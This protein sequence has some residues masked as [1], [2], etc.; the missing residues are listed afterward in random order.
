MEQE[1]SEDQIFSWKL[2][3]IILDQDDCIWTWETFFCNAIKSGYSSFWQQQLKK[4]KPKTK[5]TSH[6]QLKWRRGKCTAFV[7]LFTD[8]CFFE[9]STLRDLTIQSSR[10]FLNSKLKEKNSNCTFALESFRDFCKQPKIIL[11]LI[12]L[13]ILFWLFSTA[14]LKCFFNACAFCS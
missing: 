9:G 8:G 6:V 7:L 1:K 14:R 10:M 5:K 11:F 4:K 2:S 3:W 13:N 12:T